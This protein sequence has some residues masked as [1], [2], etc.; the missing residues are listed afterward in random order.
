MSIPKNNL[1][2]H[3]QNQQALW[4]TICKTP[5]IDYIPFQYREQW[6]KSIIQLFYEKNKQVT[7]SN[8][9]KN[10]NQDTIQYMINELKRIKQQQS[11]QQQQPS[12]PSIQSQP[13]TAIENTMYMGKNELL[14]RKQQ[15][16]NQAFTERQRDYERMFE[17]PVAPEVNF[18]EKL[19]DEPIGNIDEL[20]EKHRREREYELQQFSPPKLKIENEISDIK[21][22]IVYETEKKVKWSDEN[23]QY[24]ELKSMINDLKM[25]L[26]KIKIEL[27]IIKTD[28]HSIQNTNA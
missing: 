11:S 25:E 3:Q 28:N 6:F 26:M 5:L 14:E 21:E 23:V 8:V 24:N 18:K 27:E 16:A 9:L 10:M 19:D 22:V 13:S 17:K 20:V 4:N 7:D 1:Y 12:Q 2:I 15:F